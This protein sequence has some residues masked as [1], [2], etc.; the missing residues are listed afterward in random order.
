MLPALVLISPSRSFRFTAT[1]LPARRSSADGWRGARCSS[2]RLP[3][4]IDQNGGVLERAHHWAREL[5]R[6]GHEVRLIPPQYVKPYN[7]RNKSDAA[8]AEAIYETVGRQ[9]EIVRG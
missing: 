4:C 2:G 1:I 5:T 8:D 3:A 9:L 7:K 6:L